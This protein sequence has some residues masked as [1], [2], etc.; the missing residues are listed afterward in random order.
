MDVVEEDTIREYLEEQL[1]F[2]DTSSVNTG[3][4]QGTHDNA[5]VE[6]DDTIDEDKDRGSDRSNGSEGRYAGARAPY[7]LTKSSLQRNRLG[8][9][10]KSNEVTSHG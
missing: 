1:G 3:V 2:K 10:V 6:H 8:Y 7:S 9:M 4:S 5:E